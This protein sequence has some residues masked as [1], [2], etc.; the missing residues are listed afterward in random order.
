M[1]VREEMLEHQVLKELPVKPELVEQLDLQAV[2]GQQDRLVLLGRLDHRDLVGPQDKLALPDYQV[3][4]VTQERQGLKETEELMARRER[5]VHLE[6][7]DPMVHQ[8]NQV[9]SVR[10]VILDRPELSVQQV[11]MESK[12]WRDKLDQLEARAFLELL[13]QQASLDN[14][15]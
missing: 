5:R 2:L 14:L 10:W 8:V 7:R 4:K 3:L 15:A 11:L 1:P 12:D 13:G 9:L 6:P